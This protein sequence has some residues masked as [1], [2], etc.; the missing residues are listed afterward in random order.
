MTNAELK[1]AIDTAWVM[2]TGFLVFWMNAGFGLIEAGLCR[3]KNAVMILSKNFL[4]FAVSTLAF[5][6]VGFGL[7]FSDGGWVGTAGGLFLSGAD[8][9]P[10]TGNAYQGIFHAL[11]WTGVP[12]DAKFFFQLMFAGTSATIVSGSVNERT[13]YFP[14]VVFSLVLVGLIYPISGHWIWGGGFLAQQGFVDFAG[15]SVVHSVGGWAALAGI[16]VVGPRLGRFDAAGRALPVP[17]HNMGYVFLGGF[18]LWL[19][20][21]G[22]NPGSTMAADPVAIAR[23]ALT[24]NFAA[25]TGAVVATVYA[26]HRLGRPDFGLSVNGCLAGLVAINAGCAC[27]SNA[28]AVAI[29]AMAGVLVIEGGLFFDRIQIDDPVGATAVHL[30]HGVFGTL[31]VGLFGIKG[32]GGLHRDGL[33]HGGGFAQLGVQAEGVVAVAVLAFGGG[34][35]LWHLVKATLGVRVTADHELQGLDLAEMGMQA[36]P[37]A[38]AIEVAARSGVPAAISKTL[39]QQ[40]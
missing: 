4:V 39:P 2:L 32:L 14:F 5:W 7:M 25:A 36:Y 10:A 40:V 33:L 37:D 22:F 34:L 17:G 8:N 1:V 16:L 29:G 35:A 15:G 31:C 28:A 11:A 18:I 19:G 20:W 27:V 21:F 23:I 12:L 6:A 9:S 38:A 26:R 3:E 30:V 24:T 13:K